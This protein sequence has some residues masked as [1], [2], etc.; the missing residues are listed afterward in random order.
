MQIKRR[1]GGK[2]VRPKQSVISRGGESVRPKQS[3]IDSDFDAR[4]S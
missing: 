3:V 2:S 1:R 4:L